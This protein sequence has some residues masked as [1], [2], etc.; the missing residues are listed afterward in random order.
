MLFCT[1][2]TSNIL[3]V[4]FTVCRVC[5]ETVR[6]IQTKRNREKPKEKV[7]NSKPSDYNSLQFNPL[8][9][10]NSL[11][12]VQVRR[13]PVELEAIWWPHG[14]WFNQCLIS[15]PLNLDMRLFSVR[16]SRTSSKHFLR[17]AIRSHAAVPGHSSSQGVYSAMLSSSLNPLCSIFPSTITLPVCPV[18]SKGRGQPLPGSFPPPFHFQLLWEYNLF[19]GQNQLIWNNS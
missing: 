6:V 15:F 18:Q 19:N 13:K 3:G 9:V 2:L 12:F 5:F 14:W 7:T 17:V 4:I 10:L 11:D 16:H 8:M 1:I